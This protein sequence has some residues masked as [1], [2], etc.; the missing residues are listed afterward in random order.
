M[1]QP[2][3]R[4]EFG[5]G[6]PTNVEAEVVLGFVHLEEEW[7]KV[8]D[9]FEGP[10]W[11]VALGQRDA[12]TASESA[13]NAQLPSLFFDLPTLTSAFAAKGLSACDITVLSGGHNIGQ[14]QCQLFRARIYNE[15]N[16]DISFTESRRSI[17]PSSGGDTNLSPLD[18]L[19]PIRFDNK[20][21]SELVAGRG[22]L[23]SDQVLFD[24]GS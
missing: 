7:E 9:K 23:I 11:I 19:T 17:Y 22:L 20:Y 1:P 14:A 15:T 3:Q 21:F 16:I 8:M 4:Q 13:A 12:T 6:G 10:S 18:S 2:R 5:G 24:G